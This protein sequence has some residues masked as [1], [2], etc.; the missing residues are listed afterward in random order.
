MSGALEL[1]W[2]TWGG[3]RGTIKSPPNSEAARSLGA[4]IQTLSQ[5]QP[6]GWPILRLVKFL[7]RVL[8]AHVNTANLPDLFGINQGIRVQF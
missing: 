2:A 6:P 3:V 1:V 5:W 4:R 7:M 8:P